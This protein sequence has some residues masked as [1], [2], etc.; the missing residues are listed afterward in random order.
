MEN[1][2]AKALGQDA[3]QL[4]ATEKRDLLARLLKRLAHE[5]RN[6]LSSLGVHFQL[7]EEDLSTLSPQA[8]AQLSSRLGII[9]GELHRLESIVGRFLK[10]AGPSALELESV[11]INKIVTHV[12]ELLRPEASAR[13]VEILAELEPDLPP[14][15]VDSVR[16]TQAL[17]NII[18][19]G[20]QAISGPG[21]VK[22]SAAKSG[23]NLLLRVQ[24]TGPGIPADELGDIFDP[25][26]TTKTEGSGLGLW[27]AQQIAV[28]HGGDLR[29]ENAPGG[30]AV[31]T[32]TLPLKR[33]E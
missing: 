2:L 20:I 19:N 25:Y 1:I 18:I 27:I 4:P 16:L 23:E 10:L 30:G 24:D 28:A 9:N 5:I 8:R 13:K 17:L 31:F 12:C 22:V 15:T 6:P 11:E 29:A 7:L 21:R 3:T 33:K 32:L 14:V 26:F